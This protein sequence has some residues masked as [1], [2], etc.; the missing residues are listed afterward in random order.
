MKKANGFT[1]IELMITLVVATILMMVGIPSYQNMVANNRSLAQLNELISSIN[2]ARSLAIKKH[3]D[4]TICAS[5]NKTSCNT[6]NW[7]AGWITQLA[8]SPNV[9]HQVQAYTGNTTIRG[10]NFTGGSNSLIRFNRLGYT[11]NPGSIVL[12]DERGVKEA[13]VIHIG[14]TGYAKQGVETGGDTADIVDD[15]NGADVSCP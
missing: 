14:A 4:V 11:N 15:N 1:L 7:E 12:C 8:G 13:R 10:R 9:E 5:S 6:S 2:L 3:R